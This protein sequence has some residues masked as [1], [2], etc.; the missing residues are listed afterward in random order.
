MIRAVP[1]QYFLDGRVDNI[2]FV[3]TV[4]DTF[5]T[6]ADDQF[7]PTW[8]ELEQ[9]MDID[10]V[11]SDFRERLKALC[12]MWFLDNHEEWRGVDGG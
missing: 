7:W 2:A 3:D 12:P 1:F 10:N 5:L 9:S 8:D 6:I 4:T 11:E